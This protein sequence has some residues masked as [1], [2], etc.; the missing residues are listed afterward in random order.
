MVEFVRYERGTGTPLGAGISGYVE[1]R[2]ARQDLQLGKNRVKLSDLTTKWAEEDR[3]FEV[4]RMKREK[5]L[6]DQNVT[7]GGY[8]VQQA[9]R[10]EEIS[11]TT[12]GK[13]KELAIKML[14]SKLKQ[15]DTDERKDALNILGDVSNAL[16]QFA[17][18]IQTKDQLNTFFR[19]MNGI[20]GQYTD[21]PLF[22]EFT[23]DDKDVPGYLGNINKLDAELS[24]RYGWDKKMVDNRTAAEKSLIESRGQESQETAAIRTSQKKAEMPSVQAMRS[25]ETI[26]YDQL[27]KE[28]RVSTTTDDLGKMRYQYDGI[29]EKDI[30]LMII[31][32]A[33]KLE[34]GDVNGTSIVVPQNNQQAIDDNWRDYRKR[35]GQ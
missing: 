6:G 28:G 23:G 19:K 5:T 13:Q 11:A 8:G 32:M 33:R 15:L 18:Y 16:T 35:R 3:P 12:F 14:D 22:Q 17:P 24:T 25:A 1:G 20:I 21:L 9:G 7:I 30:E 34:S 31:E 26:V 4:E 2:K 27:M 10:E 29:S